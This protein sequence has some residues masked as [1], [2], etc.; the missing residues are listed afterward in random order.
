MLDFEK[1]MFNNLLNMFLFI[2]SEYPVL[3]NK[4]PELNMLQM[5][6]LVFHIQFHSNPIIFISVGSLANYPDIHAKQTRNLISSS[7]FHLDV[8]V[9]LFIQQEIIKPCYF[10]I[11]ALLL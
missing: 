5:E 11:I 2:S 9:H 6:F 10:V 3:N 8:S 7:L 1:Y 4:V